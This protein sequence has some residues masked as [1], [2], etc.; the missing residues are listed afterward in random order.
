METTSIKMTANDFLKILIDSK[1]KCF[2]KVP[3]GWYTRSE[4]CELWNYKKTNC[5]K[6]ITKGIKLE[7]IEKKDFYI[8]NEIGALMPIPHYYLKVSNKKTR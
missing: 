1:N 3:K 7:L 8:L 6:M 4:L 2:E 5:L